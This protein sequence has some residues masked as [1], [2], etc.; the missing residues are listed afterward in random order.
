MILPKSIMIV[1]DERSIQEYLK[2]GLNA[3]KI[4]E[5]EC[6]SNGYDVLDSLK[7]KKP[8]LILM[9]I[10][11][12]GAMDG[13]QLAKK[14][15]QRFTI[16]IIFITAYGDDET[17]EELLEISPYGFVQKPFTL[18]DLKK[19]L[20]L[21]YRRFLSEKREEEKKVYSKYT[22]I[23][24]EYTYSH[25]KRTLYKNKNE[26]KLNSKEQKLIDMLVHEIDSVVTYNQLI[27]SIWN[28]YPIAESSLRTLV[29]SIRKKMPTLPLVSYSKMG[30]SLRVE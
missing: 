12:N 23:N 18:H 15:L 22:V 1:E 8:D 2:K 13:I 14:I 28:K 30:Y 26:V 4:Q 6:F 20:L 17:F 24:S 21:G 5:L 9:D 25:E 29:Y 27:P 19:T 3:L 16:P 10:S 7:N 11:L